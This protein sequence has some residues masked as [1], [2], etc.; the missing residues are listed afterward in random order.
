MVEAMGIESNKF[1]RLKNFKRIYYPFWRGSEFYK[2][3][4]LL[5]A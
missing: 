4:V 5:R 2:S 3:Y 1:L